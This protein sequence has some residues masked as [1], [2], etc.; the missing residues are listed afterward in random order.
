M[1]NIE[2]Y[3][4]EILKGYKKR[5]ENTDEGRHS[6]LLANAI[7]KVF[8][9]DEYKRE[10]ENVV[11]W[12]FREYKAPILTDK[13]KAYLKNVIEPKRNDVLC[14]RKWRFYEGTEQEYATVTIYA[15]HPTSTSDNSFWILLDFV[16]TEEM[17]F[18]G[19][20]LEKL[21][22]LEELDL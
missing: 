15:K 11:E 22:S 14:I 13:E 20:E 16:V 17:P 2:K 6:E 21:Y 8:C 1:K 4:E 7:F 9:C 19:M 5:L 18:E 3:E 12:A 10:K